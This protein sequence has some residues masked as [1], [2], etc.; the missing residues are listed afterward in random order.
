MSTLIRKIV[1]EDVQGTIQNIYKVFTTIRARCFNLIGP[2]IEKKTST[3]NAFTPN[4]RAPDTNR[5]YIDN[6]RN[7][8][9]KKTHKQKGAPRGQIPMRCVPIKA[10]TAEH[11][12][13][14][15]NRP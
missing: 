8:K 14:S 1:L 2:F 15:T 12:R 11:T 3:S 9:P 5:K 7:H 4:A 10:H 6:G 13:S